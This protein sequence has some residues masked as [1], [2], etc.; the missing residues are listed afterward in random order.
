MDV[1]PI[2][3]SARTNHLLRDLNVSGGLW[4]GER[5]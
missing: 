1:M 4:I 5:A 2:Q 3:I